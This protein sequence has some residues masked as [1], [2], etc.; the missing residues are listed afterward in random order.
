MDR[1]TK[2]KFKLTLDDN[3]FCKT[4]KLSHYTTCLVKPLECSSEC[5]NEV[6]SFCCDNISSYWDRIVEYI[7]NLHYLGLSQN[8]IFIAM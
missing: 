7:V 5:V 6:T 3:V 1:E 2:F 8:E 4:C